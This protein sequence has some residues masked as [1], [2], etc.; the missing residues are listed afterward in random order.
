MFIFVFWKVK[1]SDTDKL[2]THLVLSFLFVQ[3]DSKRVKI[4]S[5]VTLNVTDSEQLQYLVREGYSLVNHVFLHQGV[6][7][8]FYTKKSGQS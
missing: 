5:R 4:L 3:V 7:V 6:N 8:I 1:Y 2:A